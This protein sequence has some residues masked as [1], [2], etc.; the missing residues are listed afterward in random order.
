MLMQRVLSGAVLLAIAFGD[1]AAQTAK[2]QA[3]A[4]AQSDTATRIEIYGFAQADAIGDFKSNNPDWFDV[5]RPSKLPAFE[6]EFGHN[7]HTWFSARQTR[8][9]AKATIPTSR[10]KD[11]KVVF[12]WDLFGV[13]VDAGQTTIRPRHMYGQWG[14]FGG[15]QLESPFMDLDVFPNIIEYW[16]PNGMLFY[17]NVQVFWQPVH[18]DDG[19][20]VTIALERP[21]ASG[22]AGVVA[23]RIELQNIAPRFPA[24]DISGEYRLGGKFGYAKLGAIVRWIR[25]DD[26]LPNDAFD[27]NGGVTAWGVSLSGGLNAGPWDV[28]RLQVVY[29]AGVENYFNDAPID[30]GAKRNVGNTVTPV[31]GE[32]LKDL[33]LVAYLDHKW[34]SHLSSAIGYSRVNIDNSDLQAPTA[35][36]SGQYASVNLL[37]TPVPNVMTG[38]EFQWGHRD[39]FSDGFHSN[40]YRFQF[41]LKYSFSQ[42]FGGNGN[43][44]IRAQD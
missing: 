12:D 24:P 6:D 34:N 44:I 36:K 42:K 29:G 7:G 27:L 21:G 23:D 38:G 37:W 4:K 13:G 26:L 17:R 3:K 1:L 25:W 43:E 16:G 9:G 30:V 15:G 8:F 10:G 39:N 2:P 40:D 22:D 14:D 35:F 32:A 31:T 20:R 11:I 18:R 33:G 41:A 5:N 19:T 28:V